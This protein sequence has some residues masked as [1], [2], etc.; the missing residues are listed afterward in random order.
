MGLIAL[1]SNLPSKLI[2]RSSAA[3]R[4]DGATDQEHRNHARPQQI[5]ATLAQVAAIGVVQGLIAPYFHQ[6]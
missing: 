5:Q 1:I 6:L 3:Q 2:G 4:S